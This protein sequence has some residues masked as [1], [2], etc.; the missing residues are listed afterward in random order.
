MAV[1][2]PAFF[3]AVAAE[4]GVDRLPWGDRLVLFGFLAVVAA[5]VAAPPL[6]PAVRVAPLVVSAVVLGLPHGAVDPVIPWRAA[7]RWSLPAAA[8]GVGAVYLVAGG[9]YALLWFAAPVP[10]AL[11]F[12]ALTWLHWGAGDVAALR[13]RR[14]DYPASR[15]HRVLTGAV[16]GGLP[17]VV[18]LVSSPETYRRVVESWVALFGADGAVA[19][20]ALTAFETRLLAGAAL[21]AL[22]TASLA[23]GYRATGGGPG[24]RADAAETTCLWLFF[25]AVPPLLAVGLYFCLWHS[26]RH[27]RRVQALP[28]FGPA[29]GSG[30]RSGAAAGRAALRFVRDAAPL[31]VAALALLAAAWVVV[32]DSPTTVGGAVAL[33]LVVVA[34]LTLPHTLVVAWLDRVQAVW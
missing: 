20:A 33:Y 25:L 14:S 24:W 31:T 21:A 3:A 8:A 23:V 9:A 11:T 32:P 29:A 34:A 10:A 5:V 19:L 4:T 17:M 15:R 22:T 6:P 27:V 26:L 2:R 18:P 7:D 13:A 16:R 12:L 1:T 30:S 28:A